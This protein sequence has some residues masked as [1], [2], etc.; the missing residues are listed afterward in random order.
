M[1]TIDM[2]LGKSEMQQGTSR[3]GRSQMSLGSDNRQ[4]IR[5]MTSLPHHESHD[6][7]QITKSN[8]AESAMFYPLT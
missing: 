4:L 1:M 8:L 7:S 3:P 5:R 2:V 6:L